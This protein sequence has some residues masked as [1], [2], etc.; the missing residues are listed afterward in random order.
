MKVLIVDDSEPMRRT[1]KTFVADLV[2]EVIERGDGS[3]AKA[4]YC[5]HQPDFVFMD[6]KMTAM[7]GLTATTS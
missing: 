3:E 2:H 7:D 5:E 4:A 1:I 6:L